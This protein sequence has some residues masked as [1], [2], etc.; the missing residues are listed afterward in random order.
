MLTYRNPV[1]RPLLLPR[2]RRGGALLD[3]IPGIVSAWSPAL[4][5][6]S[7]QTD[8]VTV[9][10]SGDGVARALRAVNG[11][12]TG[13]VLAAWC[14]TNRVPNSETIT[15]AAGWQIQGVTTLLNGT[16]GSDNIWLVA[17]DATNAKH[18]IGTPAVGFSFTAGTTITVEAEVRATGRPLVQLLAGSG[19]TASAINYDLSAGTLNLRGGGV[20][21]TNVDAGDGFR[22]LSFTAT[23]SSTSAASAFLQIIQSMTDPRDVAGYAGTPGL[24]VEVR[25]FRVRESATQGAYT[26]TFGTGIAAAQDGAA[27]SEV[28]PFGGNTASAPSQAAEPTIVVAGVPLLVGGLP[29]IRGDGVDDQLT[30]ALN[31]MT[32]YPLAIVMVVSGP[33]TNN[34]GS[35][36]K[37][38][39]A[40]GVSLGRG[41]ANQGTAGTNILGLKE[42]VS[43]MPTSTASPAGPA[44]VTMIQ[45]SSGPSVLRVNGTPISINSGAAT[46]ALAPTGTGF[47]MGHVYLAE[48][49]WSTELICEAVVLAREDIATINA[50]ERALGKERSIMV[51]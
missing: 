51:A 35:W 28:D 50:V 2:R 16:A 19:L 43:W 17:E 27:V 5:T 4:A 48:Q 10:R 1:R 30:F 20:S 33:S 21:G 24:G 13:D 49:R 34:R 42:A 14:G 26:P 36:V 25:R 47:L 31:G 23:A 6:R 40:N 8:V 3:G 45:P 32:S 44:V 41:A 39:A 18:R 29:A 37:L 9:R 38:G 15:A 11:R 22:L 46:A 12:V 7:G